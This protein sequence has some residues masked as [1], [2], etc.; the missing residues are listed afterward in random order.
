MLGHTFIGLEYSIQP[1]IFI[2]F[3]ICHK[4]GKSAILLFQ[5]VLIIHCS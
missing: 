1:E 3:N 4:S 5:F 2:K